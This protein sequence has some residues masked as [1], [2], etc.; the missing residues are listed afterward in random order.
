M[1]IV[2]TYFYIWSGCL[3]ISKMSL[4]HPFQYS[5]DIREGFKK[6]GGIFRTLVGWVGLKMSFSAKKIW[7]Q[8]A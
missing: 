3:K 6:K 8:N 7:S 2:H 4:K 5:K 1:Y